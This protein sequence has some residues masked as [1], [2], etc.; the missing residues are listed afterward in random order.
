MMWKAAEPLVKL[1]KDAIEKVPPLRFVYGAVGIAAAGG[2]MAMV[3]GESR[4]AIIIW[5]LAFCAM[6]LV[7]VFAQTVVRREERRP[8]VGRLL[9]NSVIVAFCGFML[10]TLTAFMNLGPQAWS[11]FLGI[12][13]QPKAFSQP[14]G[15]VNFG[16]EAGNTATIEFHA[17]AGYRILNAVVE[18]L[19]AIAAKTITPRLTFND[20][21]TAKGQVDYF[22]RDRNWVRNCPGGGHGSIIIK[23][24]IERA[25]SSLW[26]L[27]SALL[28][29]A[30]IV[31]LLSLFG[32][33]PP[34][35]VL[36]RRREGSALRPS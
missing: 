9:I 5:A 1:L 30:L 3:L 32:S 31:A 34:P 8:L 6:V 12:A 17:P 27:V 33:S 14:G 36:R 23:G 22:G 26:M 24:Q 18:P 35:S 7:T 29:L 10:L 16:C 11:D 21:N 4:A 25:T 2:L 28:V 19:D 13:S 20:G 15:T